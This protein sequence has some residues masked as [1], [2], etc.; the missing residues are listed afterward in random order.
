MPVS[1]LGREQTGK[2]TNTEIVDKHMATAKVVRRE[3][4]DHEVVQWNL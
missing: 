4:K 2:I 1:G 3:L